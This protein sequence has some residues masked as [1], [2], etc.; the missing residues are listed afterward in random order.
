MSLP[1][2]ITT[3]AFGTIPSITW[4]VVSREGAG[5]TR[6]DFTNGYFAKISHSDPVA[7][8]GK[9]ARHYLQIS[10]PKDVLDPATGLTRRLTATASISVSIPPNGWTTAEA[11]AFV[12]LLSVLIGDSEFTAV[13]F[14]KFQS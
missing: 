9:S 11:G 7:G 5:S 6:A 13:N 10:Q 12:D 1:D 14:V 2:P 4:G 3:A 8:S